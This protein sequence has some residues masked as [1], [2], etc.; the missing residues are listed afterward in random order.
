MDW[1]L[2]F[3]IL[4]VLL[5]IALI[6]FLVVV[7]I[8]FYKLAKAGMEFLDSARDLVEDTHMKISTFDEVFETIGSIIEFV[9]DIGTKVTKYLKFKDIK[10]DKK[11]KEDKYE[12]KGKS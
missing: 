4:Y 12:E 10:K 9:S 8:N 2:V 7:A 11:C 5:I 3:N 6:F 1:T